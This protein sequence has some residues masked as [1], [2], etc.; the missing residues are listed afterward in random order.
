MDRV[1]H[2]PFHKVQTGLGLLEGLAS[3]GDFD[4]YLFDDGVFKKEGWTRED[5]I[6]A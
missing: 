2:Q 1:A 3:L 6:I 5:T 4:A